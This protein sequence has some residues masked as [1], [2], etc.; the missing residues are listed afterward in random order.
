[1][2]V[3]VSY[4]RWHPDIG[5]LVQALYLYTFINLLFVVISLPEVVCLVKTDLRYLLYLVSIHS[6]LGAFLIKIVLFLRNSKTKQRI[7]LNVPQTIFLKTM[8]HNTLSQLC[9]YNNTI[10]IDSNFPEQLF[11]LDQFHPIV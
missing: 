5:I 11:I 10:A 1:M 4:P 2:G 9:A 8:I 6:A 3:Y 7:K